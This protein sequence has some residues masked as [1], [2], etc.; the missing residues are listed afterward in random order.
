[1]VHLIIVQNDKIFLIII[2]N[3][4]GFNI[5]MNKYCWLW[6]TEYRIQNTL[7]SNYYKNERCFNL[8][9]YS[10]LMC[11]KIICNGKF[12]KDWLSH[13]PNDCFLCWYIWFCLLK[14]FEQTLIVYIICYSSN[15]QFKSYILSISNFIIFIFGNPYYFKVDNAP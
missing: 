1:M 8:G 4:Y 9:N 3:K 10:I 7:H 14:M 2:M 13:H 15:V 5:I 11:I 6:N 12:P